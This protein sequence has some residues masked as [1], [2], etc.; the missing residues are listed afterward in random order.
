MRAAVVIPAHNEEDFI[1]PCLRSVVRSIDAYGAAHVDIIVVADGCTD[2]TAAIAAHYGTVI[3]TEHRQVGLAR[4]S[5]VLAALQHAA[6]GSAQYAA[7]GSS[8][9]ALP[10]AGAAPAE[11]AVTWI[12]STD[13]DCLVPPQ[14]VGF[15]LSAAALADVVLGTVQPLWEHSEDPHTIDRYQQRYHFHED[16]PHIHG[17]NMSFSAAAY[18]EVGGFAHIAESEDVALV[19]AMRRAGKRIM[20]TA[21]WPVRTST[22]VSSRTPGGF[23]G[24]LESIRQGGSISP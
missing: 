7:Q 18:R 10:G 24:Y 2:N 21:R 22:R 15:H 23:S 9:P 12:L 3:H 5:G 20:S 11:H 4:H 16:H 6:E 19:A 1:G 8:E 17:A 14:W 13:A